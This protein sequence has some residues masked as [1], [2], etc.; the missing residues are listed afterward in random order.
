MTIG[1][2]GGTAF[3]QRDLGTQEECMRCDTVVECDARDLMYWVP[4][5]TV[6][7]YECRMS[8]IEER[9]KKMKS[10]SALEIVQSKLLVGTKLYQVYG[11]V[12]TASGLTR[13]P[14]DVP[15]TVSQRTRTGVEFKNDDGKVG[16]MAWPDLRYIRLTDRGFEIVDEE[17]ATLVRYE[18]HVDAQLAAQ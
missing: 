11:P 3:Y 8:L 13:Q 6:L 14:C 1:E 10:R 5:S 15:K 2:M 18:W 12:R 9:K 4:L 7:L 17:D 16:E